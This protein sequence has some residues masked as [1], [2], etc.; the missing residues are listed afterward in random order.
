MTCIAAMVYGNEVFMA[1]DLMGSNGFTKKTYTDSKV[2]KNGDFVIGYTSSFRMGQLL[3]F[4]WSQPPRVEGLSDREYLQLDVIESMRTMFNTYGY[5]VKDGLED[6]GG[7]FLIGYNGSL[8]EMQPNFSVLKNDDFAAIGSGQYHAE[9][10]LATLIN[11]D[12][13]P[14]EVLSKAIETAARFTT[15]VSA[16]CTFVTTY[17]PT[18]EE[19][20][21]EFWD[22]NNRIIDEELETLDIPQEDKD[23]FIRVRDMLDKELSE[24]EET[25]VEESLEEKVNSILK[26]NRGLIDLLD[27][28]G[29]V[30]GVIE[31]DTVSEE[32]EVTVETIMDYIHLDNIDTDDRQ[33]ILNIM[34]NCDPSGKWSKYSTPSLIKKFTQAIYKVI[35]D[36]S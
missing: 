36:N 25:F 8:Y 12:C 28:E 18:E 26:S 7:N 3:Q 6:I 29:A 23:A 20:M 14:T 1:G 16:E 27:T 10:V 35:E 2:F 24:E 19:V 22:E 32:M 9:A 5:G 13:A 11:E 17:V 4:N 31:Y 30:I 21:E 15:S 34:D 33:T